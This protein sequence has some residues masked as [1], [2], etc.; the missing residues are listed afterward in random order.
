M[1]VQSD[2][3]SSPTPREMALDVPLSLIIFG[4]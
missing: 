1:A 2:S 4:K 3:N